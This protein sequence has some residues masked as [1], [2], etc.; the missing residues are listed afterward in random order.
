METEGID[1]MCPICKDYLLQPRIYEC[2]HTICE[3]CMI[4]CDKSVKSEVRSTFDT[5]I[6][7]CP[8]CRKTTLKSW[9]YRPVNHTLLEILM[10]NKEFAESQNK[11]RNEVDDDSSEIKIPDDINLATIARAKRLEKCNEIYKTIIPIVF[12]AAME[13]KPY[14]TITH[15]TTEIQCIADLLANRLFTDHGVWRLQSN[16]R[17]CQIDIIPTNRSFQAEYTNRNYQ[18]HENDDDDDDD[19][20][21]ELPSTSTIRFHSIRSLRRGMLQPHHD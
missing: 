13:G 10:K 14:I 9:I 18:R 12:H 15:N 8:L 7:K 3:R 21:E 1:Y 6:Y 11:Y 16:S 2:G 19:D 17:E 20:E 4:N 5:P